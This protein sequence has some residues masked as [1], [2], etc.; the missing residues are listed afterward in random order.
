[1]VQQREELKTIRKAFVLSTFQ[2]TMK[3]HDQPTRLQLRYLAHPL[4]HAN[5]QF[6][7]QPIILLSGATLLILSRQISILMVFLLPFTISSIQMPEGRNVGMS[8]DHK[9][10]PNFLSIIPISLTS[11]SPFKKGSLHGSYS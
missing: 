3:L 11:H 1:M 6:H 4:R 7:N 9:T 10:P 8:E 5:L 2:Y